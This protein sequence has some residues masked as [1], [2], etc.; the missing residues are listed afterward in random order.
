MIDA[1]YLGSDQCMQTSARLEP[2]GR[3]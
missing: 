3:Y 2:Q 1:K